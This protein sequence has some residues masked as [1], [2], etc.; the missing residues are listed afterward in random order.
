MTEQQEL[1]HLLLRLQ[2]LWS[3]EATIARRI[4]AIQQR[5]LELLGADR[6]RDSNPER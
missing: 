1:L 3:Q 2:D 6:G 4:F 5:Q